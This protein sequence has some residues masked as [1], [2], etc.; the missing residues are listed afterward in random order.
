MIDFLEQKYKDKTNPT[1]VLKEIDKKELVLL[2]TEAK[3][4]IFKTTEVSNTFQVMVFHLFSNIKASPRLCVCSKCQVEYGSCELFSQYIVEVEQLKKMNSRS[5]HIEEFL[6]KGVVCG[7]LMSDSICAVAAD[8]MSSD[9][10]W[11]IRLHSNPDEAT[12]YITDDYGNNIASEQTYLCVSYCEKQ[13]TTRSSQVYS[14]M[15]KVAIT[16]SNN[17]TKTVSCIHTS[18]Q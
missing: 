2:R 14:L 5:A 8:C 11:L 15:N 18:I 3:L 9:T 13:K 6:E 17:Y 10:V 1:Y 4:K 16:S 12:A 7:F